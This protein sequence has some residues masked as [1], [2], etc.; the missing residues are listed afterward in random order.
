P[1]P[2]HLHLFF[3]SQVA[4]AASPS[5][6]IPS[7]LHHRIQLGR[8]P[9]LGVVAMERPASTLVQIHGIFR[10]RSKDV[11]AAAEASSNIP[12]GMH[13][14]VVPACPASGGKP[15]LFHGAGKCLTG[16]SEERG[17]WP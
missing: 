9:P 11:A 17:R 10:W 6:P 13:G 1:A 16:A 2:V 8:Q 14:G 5:P 12:A 4:A 15:L 3:P 7:R